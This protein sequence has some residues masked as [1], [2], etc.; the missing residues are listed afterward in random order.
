MVIT[1][2]YNNHIDDHI[3]HLSITVENHKDVLYNDTVYY[4]IIH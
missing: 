4:M 1:K 2:I 3:Y